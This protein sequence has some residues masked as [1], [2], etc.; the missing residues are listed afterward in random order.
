MHAGTMLLWKQ[1]AFHIHLIKIYHVINHT[2]ELYVSV[3]YRFFKQ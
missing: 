3:D 1:Q 2:H